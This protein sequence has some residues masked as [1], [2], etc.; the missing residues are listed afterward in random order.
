MYYLLA[1]ANTLLFGHLLPFRRE[2]Q[3]RDG[4]KQGKRDM[5]S[6]MQQRFL[7]AHEPGAPISRTMSP[8]QHHKEPFLMIIFTKMQNVHTERQHISFAFPTACAHGN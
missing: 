1:L 4:G 6:D 5:G 8:Y 7:A 3:W 2:T